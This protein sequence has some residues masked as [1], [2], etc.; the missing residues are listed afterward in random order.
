MLEVAGVDVWYGKNHVL[1]DLS[2]SVKEGEVVALVG[3][4][5]AGKTTTMRSL[6]GLKEMRAGTVRLAGADLSGADTIRRVRSGLVLV[7]EGRQVFPKFSVADNLSMG[8]YH[9][10]DRNDVRDE[11]EEV[12]E[13]FPRLRERRTQKAG[14]MSGGEQQM[15]ALARGLLSRPRCLLLDEPVLGL[16]PLI[17][18]E[19]ESIIRKLAERGI[20]VLLAEQNAAMALRLATRAYVLE[21]G[22]IS[23]SGTTLQLQENESVR[24]LYLGT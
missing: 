17:I 22:R 8:A 11:V 5:A 6:M 14:S 19:I 7:P 12:F 10:S 23:A 2:F 9:R 1:R 21:S 20:S 16:A 13:L 15:L 24:R 18:R 4:N 3:S